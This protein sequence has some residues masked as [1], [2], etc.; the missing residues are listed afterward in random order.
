MIERIDVSDIDGT[1]CYC[2]ESSAAQIRQRISALPLRAVHLLGTGDYHYLSLFFLERITEEFALVLFDNHPDDQSGAFDEGL[3]SC[4]SWVRSARES[5]QKMKADFR[6]A[7][8]IVPGDIP[9]YLSI[10]LDVLDPR[11]AHTDWD[12]GDYTL[13][14]LKNEV[15]EALSG[16]KLIGVD[17]CGGLKDPE[18]AGN[19][20]N[21]AAIEAICDLVSNMLH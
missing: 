11:F 13:D 15:I 10:D 19:E 12:Q 2:S 7:T 18:D 16:H 21:K 9:I 4:G 1:Y 6:N 17:I 5:L 8:D 14:R 20:L 3:L